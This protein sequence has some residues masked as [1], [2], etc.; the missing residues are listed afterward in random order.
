MARWIALLV[1]SSMLSAC[2]SSGQQTAADPTPS[3]I[4]SASSSLA[5]II[6]DLGEFEPP[7]FEG[8]GLAIALDAPRF[9]VYAEPDLDSE[10]M[11]ELESHNPAKQQLNFLV[12]SAMADADGTGWFEILVP[13]R[14]NGSKGWVELNDDLEVFSIDER[15]E[16][17]LSDYELRYYKKG[18]LRE[19]F[20]VGVGQ[21]RYPTPVGVFYVWAHV[22]QPD[23]E[24]PYGNLALGLSGFSPVLSDWPGGG[25]AAVHGTADASDKGAKVSHGCVRVFNEDMRKLRHIRLGTPVLIRP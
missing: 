2:A 14:P 18:Q 21:D 22:P 13:E 4:V 10:P 7:G 23:K 6:E 8:G 20:E 17:D 24:G 3:P 12:L 16:V 25:R 19:T 5:P 9:P 11:M 1:L 15:I